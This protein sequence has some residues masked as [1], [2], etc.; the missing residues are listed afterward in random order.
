MNTRTSINLITGPLGSG[1][2]TLIRHLLT[3]KPEHETWV[4]LVNEFGSVG[5][6]GAILSEH[7]ST[8]SIQ[9]PGGCI[10]CTAKTEL[11]QTLVD[12]IKS[13]APNRILIEPTGL[14]EP[15]TLVD[16]LQT[17]ALEMPIQLQTLFAV[18]DCSAVTLKEIDDFTIMQNLLNMADIVIL[19]KHDLATVEQVDTLQNYCNALFPAKQQILLTQQAKIA[20]KWLDHQHADYSPSNH[21]QHNGH[22][23]Q[24]G[25]QT[26]ASVG[27][28]LPYTPI[29]FEQP[30]KRLYKK[31]LGIQSIGFIFSNQVTFDWKKLFQLFDS[32]NHSDGFQ[33][34][35][36]AK[37]V[38]KVGEPWML[39]Q[40]VN[41]HA[42]RE[43][44]TYRRD[45]RLELLLEQNA[46]FNFAHFENQLKNCIQ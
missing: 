5:I 32:L 1:K 4:L 6:D 22:Q 20:A 10:C 37:G 34:V 12:V 43:Y 17:V 14:G 7:S 18:L 44:I 28:M 38:L 35:K 24:H 40:W 29:L 3:L 39:F 19:N 9:L 36:R 30:P 23:I 42:T 21:C 33:G 46:K 11:Q 45:S 2:T 27:V 25:H 15:D 16:I 31:E 41:Q 13:H 26:S 8:L